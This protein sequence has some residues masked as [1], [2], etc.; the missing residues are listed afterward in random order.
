MLRDETLLAIH[1]DICPNDTQDNR[2]VTT[3]TRS[4]A[5]PRFDARDPASLPSG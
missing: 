4:Y 1:V 3:T 5:E 2:Q